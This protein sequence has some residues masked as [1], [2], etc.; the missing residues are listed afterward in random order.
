MSE[1]I[2]PLPPEGK[3]RFETRLIKHNGAMRQAIFIDGEMLDWSINMHD[4]AEAAKM[5][6]QYLNVIKEDIIKH[7]TNSVS[8]FFVIFDMAS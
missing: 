1:I 4:F 6:P 7:F 8:D 2:F 5:G 3:K